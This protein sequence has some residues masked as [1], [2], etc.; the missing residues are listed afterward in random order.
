MERKKVGLLQ[1]AFIQ[2]Q[3]E[4]LQRAP[5][6]CVLETDPLEPVIQ[7]MSSHKI[8]CMLVTDSAGRVTG[9]FTE[10]DITRRVYGKVGDLSTTAICTVM[11]GH[12]QTLKYNS[13]IGKALHLMAVGGFR[14]IPVHQRDGSWSII[15]VRDFIKFLHAKLQS[16]KKRQEKGLKVFAE[17]NEVESF[18][19]GRIS[20]MKTGPAVTVPE[21]TSTAESI[22]RMSAAGVSCLVIT[23]ANPEQVRGVFSERDLLTKV[24]MQSASAGSQPISNFMTREPVTFM[25]ST[26]VLH[27]LRTMD[28][29]AFRHVPLVDFDER[30][31]GLLSIQDFVRTLAD[32]VVQTLTESTPKK[33]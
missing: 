20:S 28:E 25:P 9:I 31:V 32:G 16:R 18:L 7:Q 26:S 4:I 3:L 8:G 33:H 29:R 27:A 21:T 19:T 14:H 1:R 2:S 11:T 24:V 10:R 12:P 17:D 22:E 30:L 6:R 23:T 15:S 13:S 5:A